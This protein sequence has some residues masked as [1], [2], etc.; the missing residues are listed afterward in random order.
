VVH[1]KVHRFGVIGVINGLAVMSDNETN[2]RWDHITGEAFDGPLVGEKLDV[3][4]IRMT[5]VEAALI[6][7]PDVEVYFSTYFS[8]VWWID[9][10][11]YSRFIKS[12][13][14]FPPM[15]Y[16]SLSKPVDP[17]LP[18]SAQGLGVIVGKRAKYYP[19]KSMVG[20][21]IE[22]RWGKRVLHIKRNELDGVP[23]ATWKDTGERPMQLLTRWYGFSFT[24]PGCEIWGET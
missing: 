24:Y 4:P 10:R 21:D 19:I 12:W 1:G 7:A 5:T 22:D 11:I 20:G 9:Q 15:F 6:E 14:W 23:Y 3:W 13:V 2:S 8:W 16:L 18:R 17:R